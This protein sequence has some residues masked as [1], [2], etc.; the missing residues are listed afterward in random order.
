[1]VHDD[2]VAET[3]N[4]YLVVLVSQID[5]ILLLGKQLFDEGILL[6][7]HFIGITCNLNAVLL[8]KEVNESYGQLDLHA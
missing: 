8:N 3:H 5:N 4:S 2:L 1:M 7:K 6:L